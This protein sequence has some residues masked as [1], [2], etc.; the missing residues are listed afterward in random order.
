MACNNTCSKKDD[1][2]KP[3]FDKDDKFDDKELV[4]INGIKEKKPIDNKPDFE[5]PNNNYEKPNNDKDEKPNDFNFNSKPTD[6]FQKPNF[7]KDNKFD[8][9]EPVDPNYIEEK[10][11]I[12]NKPDFK[13]PNNK[14]EKPNIDKDEKPNDFD[15]NNKPVDEFQKPNFDKDVEFE[16]KDPVDPIIFEE[17]KSVNNKPEFKKPNNKYE[18][19]NKD[20]KQIGNKPD[21]EKPIINGEKPIIYNEKPNVVVDNDKDSCVDL[22]QFRYKNKK[23]KGCAWV[24]RKPNKRCNIVWKNKK[25]SGAYCPVACG[26]CK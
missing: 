16:N 14:Y 24:G 3:G 18:K 22:S 21:F 1:I 7:Y 11:N 2:V 13:K 8:E 17:E 15:F 10:K 23:N 25:V 5:K 9:K 20:K 6:D 12:S 26:L 19:P 4:D